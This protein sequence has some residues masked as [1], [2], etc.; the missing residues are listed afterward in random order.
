MQW[1][2]TNSVLL[3][4]KFGVGDT[5]FDWNDL[6]YMKVIGLALQEERR[7]FNDGGSNDFY[8]KNAC[9]YKCRAINMAVQSKRVWLSRPILYASNES[10][11]ISDRYYNTN[12]STQIVDKYHHYTYMSRK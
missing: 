1:F 3:P 5:V 2:V 11:R 7:C 4:L 9:V 8:I 10:C 6:S 12:P